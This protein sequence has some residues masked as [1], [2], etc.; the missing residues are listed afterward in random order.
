MEVTSPT[1]RTG[2]ATTRS[3]DPASNRSALS[4]DFETFLLMLTT[5]MQNQD[6]LNPL[7]SS[8]FAV[9]L[10][11]FSGVEQQVKTNDL[12]ES[13]ISGL[14]NSGIAQMASWI[15]KEV[16]TDGPAYYVGSP[17]TLYPQREENAD[18]ATLVVR[19]ETGGVVSRSYLGPEGEIT[20]AGVGSDGVQ[21]GPGLYRFEVENGS[22]GSAPSMTPVE[23]Y[24]TVKEV[25]T[26]ADGP[27]LV[28]TGGVELNSNDILSVR[29]APAI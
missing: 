15:G 27:R 4:S 21:L 8:E 23:H 19:N 7:Q 28:L 16:R 29:D 25:R 10:A 12:L 13:L 14:T 24:T 18:L 11:T 20:W 3:P 5:Q 22:G 9:Q 26:G 1:D 6:P 2:P 17:L